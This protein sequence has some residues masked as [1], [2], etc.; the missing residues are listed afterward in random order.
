MHPKFQET[1]DSIAAWAQADPAVQ[2]VIIIGSQARSTILSDQWSDLDLMLFVDDQQA[3]M[4]DD[5]WTERFGQVI[6]QFDE[7]VPLHFTNWKWCVKRP[8]YADLRDVDF[9]VLPYDRL[10][11]VLAV[12]RDIIARGYR[13]IYDSRADLLESK[14]R[15]LL[16]AAE[17]EGFQVLTEREFQLVVSELLYHVV[18]AFKKI[19]RGELWVA[20]NCI[21][22]HMKNLLFRLIEAHNV[23]VRQQPDILQY[24]GRFLEQRTDPQVLAML[25]RCFTH[26]D[27]ADA[28]AALGH[29]HEITHLLARAIC[30]KTGYAFD[31]AQFDRI[32]AVYDEMRTSEDPLPA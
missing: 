13:V 18:W 17:P 25:E 23:T 16:Q 2:G 12:N 26:Y 9:S 6:C 4:Q 3:M 8:L 28:V 27:R 14:I 19:K 24:Y 7:I 20:A 5:T 29:L 32:K 11:E 21:N 10:D 31:A 15:A 1:I 30:E 22:S